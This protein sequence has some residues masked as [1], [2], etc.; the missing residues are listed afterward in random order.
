[1]TSNCSSNEQLTVA[2]SSG[3]LVR[4]SKWL[5]LLLVL[6]CLHLSACSTLPLEPPICLPF[7]PVLVDLSPEAQLMIV[8][9]VPQGR[10]VLQT[11][12][13]NDLALKSHVRLLEGLIEG[14]DEPLG[15]CE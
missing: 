10:D 15:G 5:G 14:H 11:I 9:R 8:D 12:G 7:R 6:G 1:M 4:H 13:T 2:S 3:Q